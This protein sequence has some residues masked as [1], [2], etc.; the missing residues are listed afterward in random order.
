MNSKNTNEVPNFKPNHKIGEIFNQLN[1][2]TPS[3]ITSFV[4]EYDLNTKTVNNYYRGRTKDLKT[5][6]ALM[7]LKFFNKHKHPD[8]NQYELIDLYV[9]NSNES[10]LNDI[11]L[12]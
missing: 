4:D 6:I 5:P 11:D 1:G 2:H 8:I 3:L 9:I 10:I 7:F 12:K